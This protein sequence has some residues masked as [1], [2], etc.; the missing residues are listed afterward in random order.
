MNEPSN[1]DKIF[2]DELVVLANN[3]LHVLDIDNG[4]EIWQKELP[5]RYVLLCDGLGVYIYV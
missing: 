4:E 2:S 5:N 3:K 1:I